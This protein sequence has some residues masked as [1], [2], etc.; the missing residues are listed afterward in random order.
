[1]QFR[2]RR[3]QQGHA[4]M[5][6]SRASVLVAILLT[7]GFSFSLQAS[8]DM[9]LDI[10]GIPGESKDSVHEGQVDVLAWNWGLSIP[11][12]TNGVR[13][14]QANFQDLNVI[15]YVDTSSPLLMLHCANSHQI[16]TATLYVRTQGRTPIEFIK[17]IMTD[18]LVTSVTPGGSEGG[19]R[20][21]ENVSLNFAKV[22]FDYTPLN[23]NG[24]VS[25]TISLDWNIPENYG[26]VISPVIGLAATLIYTNGAP[27]AELTW[28]SSSGANYQVWAASDLNAAFQSYGGPTA[29]AGDGTTSIIVP[30]DAIRKFF[31]IETLSSQ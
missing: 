29:S 22:E 20:L 23:P 17:M 28:N 4:L 16:T 10:A 1:M 11:P 30:A 26:S 2:N 3:Y 7:V 15:K 27:F 13:V 31:R 24:S 25:S 18:I 5:S 12:P 21:I 19:D 8:F 14:A 9:F 6:K